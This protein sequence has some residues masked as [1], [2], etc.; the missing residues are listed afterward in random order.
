MKS[1]RVRPA[2]VGAFAVLIFLMMPLPA[3]AA[4]Q[5]SPFIRGVYGKDGSSSGYAYVAAS[6][7]NSVMTG[8]YSEL[9]DGVTSAGLRGVVWLGNF[10]NAPKCNFEKDDATVTRLVRS[11]AGNPAVVAYYLGD[12][13]HVTE[14]PGA[15]KRFR[16]RSALVHSL[17][18]AAR[19]FTVIQA[20][21]NG[22]SHDYAPWA[23]SVDVIG[24]DVY[25]CVRSSNTCNFGAIDS[26]ISA[27]NSAGIKNYWAILQDFQDCYYRL[28]KPAE[29]ASQFDH[30]SRSNMSGYFVFSWNYQPA[31]P[32]C[33]GVSLD[34]YGANVAQLKN[35][36]SRVFKPGGGEST[37][38]ADTAGATPEAPIVAFVIVGLALGALSLLALRAMPRRGLHRS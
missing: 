11:V 2:A 30:W 20:S 24:F 10:L 38:S 34:A 16:E 17:D 32:S 8:P 15:P 14:C 36:N 3:A 29:L 35:E 31:N 12:E 21:E 25:P 7:F 13:P 1:I 27:I 4:A 5:Q 6:G 23:G 28:P 9:L 22:V 18:P 26:A 33:T 19:T 37:G